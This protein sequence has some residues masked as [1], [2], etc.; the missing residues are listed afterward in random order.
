MSRGW[1]EKGWIHN[2]HR[3]EK[4]THQKHNQERNQNIPINNS[5]DI[6]NQLLE[7]EEVESPH[8]KN[9]GQR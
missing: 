6:L 9:I 7:E 3:K 8:K 1:K 5:F 4:K 2:D